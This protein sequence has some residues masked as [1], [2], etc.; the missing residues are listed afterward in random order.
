MLVPT[1]AGFTLTPRR[2]RSAASVLKRSGSSAAGWTGNGKAS[3]ANSSSVIG[4]VGDRPARFAV[5]SCLGGPP[6]G[7]AWPVL[8][9]RVISSSLALGF[10]AYVNPEYHRN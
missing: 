4:R 8:T 5:G 6:S 10:G 1:V 2:I 7:G 9:L 3:A